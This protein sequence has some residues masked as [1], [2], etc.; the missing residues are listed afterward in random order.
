MIHTGGLYAHDGCCTTGP[1]DGSL[2]VPVVQPPLKSM[3]GG[4]RST[5]MSCKG[6]AGAGAGAVRALADAHARPPATSTVAVQTRFMFQHSGGCFARGC[7]GADART[8]AA[9]AGRR[10]LD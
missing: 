9:S 7:I 5:F 3:A 10:V 1:G 2:P 6:G 8:R 4:S